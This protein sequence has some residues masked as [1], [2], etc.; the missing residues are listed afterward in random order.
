[1]TEH[2]AAWATL[3]GSAYRAL[4]DDQLK[5]EIDRRT[6]IESRG[7]QIIT[8][9]GGIVAL[10]FALAAVVTN[11]KSFQPSAGTKAVLC[12]A[13]VL[14]LAASVCGIATSGLG[15]YG[16]AA[17]NALGNLLKDEYWRGDVVVAQR[18]VAEL[19]V[20]LI[21]IARAAN[22]TKARIVRGGLAC[23]ILGIVAVAVAVLTI[24]A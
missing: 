18:R 10:L 2:E 14:L 13:L 21:G 3:A 22:D 23:E 20:N 15:E 12:V 8:S 19:E 17:D 4:I 16:A 1:V 7:L 6:A 24:L 9:A 11:L 5:G